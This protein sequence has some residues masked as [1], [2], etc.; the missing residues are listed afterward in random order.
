[1]PSPLRSL[2]FGLCLC[3]SLLATPAASAQDSE[4]T[5]N[6]L[7]DDFRHYV[8]TRQDEL[9]ESVGVAL[10]NKSLTPEQF[11]GLVE[12]S[13]FGAE[14][15]E[16]SIRRGLFIGSVESVA[17]QLEQLYQQGRR[18]KARNPDEIA[19]NINLLGGNQRGRIL[20]TQRLQAAGEYAVPQ[21]LQVLLA[22]R[23]PDLEAE[24]ERV[25]VALGADAVAPLSAALLEVDPTTQARLAVILGLTRHPAALA[26][27]YELAASTDNSDVRTA[28]TRAISR[29]AGEYNPGLSLSD[30]Y[31]LLAEDYYDHSQS[32]T[33]F[34]GEEHQL[35]WS[36]D[37]ALGLYATPIR[38]EVF[39]DV[40]AMQ[41][42]EKALALEPTNGRAVSL[43][44]AA[45]FKREIDTP[46]G[47][48]D[49]IYGAGRRDALY[50]AVAAGSAITQEVL[51][52][53]LADR[54]TPLARRAIRALRVS[55][56][57][58][59]IWSGSG[60]V[61]PLLDALAY[62]DRRVRYEAALAI[63]AANPV[64]P[65][66]GADR[67]TPLLASAIR[68]AGAR[69]A[70]VIT[71]EIDIQPEWAYRLHSAGFTVLAPT[72]TLA[73]AAPEIADS[74]GVDLIVVQGSTKVVQGVLNAV[75]ADPRLRATPILGVLP[76]AGWN[77][78]RFRY[79]N[80]PLT[81]VRREGL[82][83]A[84]LSD[85]V[86]SLTRGASGPAITQEQAHEYAMDALGVLRDLAISGSSSLSVTDAATPLIAALDD[87]EGDVR[88]RVA[89]VL[90]RIGERRAQV[91]L[92]DAALDAAGDE[93]VALLEK[94][95]RSAKT[96]GD[97]LEK[98]HVRRLAKLAN[99]DENAVAT[100]AAALM[101]ALNLQT[102]EIR[103]LILAVR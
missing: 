5:P 75:R 69:F 22:K 60:S 20:A 31:R 59:G 78:L 36:F 82:D 37:P 32:L 11:V 27:L 101:G 53:A 57:G 40:R 77:E 34:P 90:A 79:Q 1:M 94:V 96:F 30:L 98:R 49:P 10:L 62:P 23:N 86:A 29:I 25:L 58:A 95:T 89:D 74:P 24:A 92:M 16:Q 9:A 84:Q 102:G 68:D 47:Y 6:E 13:R 44:I 33:R 55:A 80:D 50:F 83:D 38:T 97:M 76:V 91:A 15:F 28:A 48:K 2:L 52:R 18:D 100:A 72:K 66:D 46:E 35:A 93:Q 73:D 56:G 63:G 61:R 43:W 39:P 70:V 67:V 64:E 4:P 54:D 103:D 88:M 87:T 71:P 51:A 81:T 41:L 12:D 8:I 42:A 3:A 85:A 7:L 26:P 65:F 19:K 21:L 99:S 17:A 45:D 14:G